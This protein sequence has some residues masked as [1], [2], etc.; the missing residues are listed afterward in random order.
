LSAPTSVIERFV[1]VRLLVFGP[2]PP[3][4]GGYYDLG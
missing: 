4:A 3:C 2:S 1:P